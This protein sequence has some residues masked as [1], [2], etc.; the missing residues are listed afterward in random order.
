M[1]FLRKEKKSA[2]KTDLLKKVSMTGQTPEFFSFG[3][4]NCVF[5]PTSPIP[6]A[7]ALCLEIALAAVFFTSLDSLL[8]TPVNYQ[9]ATILRSSH[10]FLVLSCPYSNYC[11]CSIFD[12]C[13]DILSTAKILDCSVAKSQA[14]SSFAVS[15][16]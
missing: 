3:G 5:E 13:F 11:F 2:S 12:G 15:C 8:F 14:K 6:V 10:K 9:N 7:S 1:I 16:I 4:T